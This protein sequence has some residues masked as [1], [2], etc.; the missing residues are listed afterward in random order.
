MGK[1]WAAN[2][3]EQL[4]L[5][6]LFVDKKV[7]D[8]MKPSEVQKKYSIFDGFTAAVFRRHWNTTKKMFFGFSHDGKTI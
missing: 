4:Y 2:G 7:D 5:E 3:D 1:M 8:T 6:K